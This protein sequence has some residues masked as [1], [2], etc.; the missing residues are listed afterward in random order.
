MNFFDDMLFLNHI[1][2]DICDGGL[3]GDVPSGPGVAASHLPG[4]GGSVP[5]PALY[6]I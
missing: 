6:Q 2:P 4:H 3:C 1:P 5:P